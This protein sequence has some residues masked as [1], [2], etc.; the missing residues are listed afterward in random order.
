[1][2]SHYS[3]D[4]HDSRSARGAE[5]SLGQT[6]Y[7]A[8]VLPNPYHHHF[9]A[10]GQV[11]PGWSDYLR[12]LMRI[13]FKI[14]RI[15]EVELEAGLAEQVIFGVPHAAQLADGTG[16]PHALEDPVD[17]ATLGVPAPPQQPEPGF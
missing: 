1:V 8:S 17:E 10:A 5:L 9:G 7:L 11:T 14:N 16:S 4:Q 3:I 15:S 2:R 13:A 6:L 12:R